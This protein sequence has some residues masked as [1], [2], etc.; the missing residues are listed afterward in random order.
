MKHDCF[1]VSYKGQIQEKAV[2]FLLL[3]TRVEVNILPALFF[4]RKSTSQL[5]DLKHTGSKQLQ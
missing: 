2:S 1:S 4:V 5:Q 3:N